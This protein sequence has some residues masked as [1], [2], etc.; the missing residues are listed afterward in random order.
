MCVI[1]SRKNY[2]LEHIGEKKVVTKEAR[3]NYLSIPSV[4]KEAHAIRG[5][6]NLSFSF[7]CLKLIGCSCLKKLL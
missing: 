3:F 6:N 7:F 2:T 5:R 1:N 4:Y